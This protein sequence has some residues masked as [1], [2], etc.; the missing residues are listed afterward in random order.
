MVNRPIL[1]LKNFSIEVIVLLAAFFALE[2]A[3]RSINQFFFYLSIC[4][5]W[6]LCSLA[7]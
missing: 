6:T 7:N 4:K 2:Q 1:I 3:L 5:G